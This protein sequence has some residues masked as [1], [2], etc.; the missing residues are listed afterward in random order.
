MR[1]R[2][3]ED[4]LGTPSHSQDDDDD[5]DLLLAAGL[6]TTDNSSNSTPYYDII[7]NAYKNKALNQDVYGGRRIS[8]RNKYDKW[9][10]VEKI[11]QRLSMGLIKLGLRLRGKEYKLF[12]DPQVELDKEKIKSILQDGNQFTKD[13]DMQNAFAAGGRLL[14][15][16]GSL[17]ILSSANK[18]VGTGKGV[19]KLD[20]M[21]MSH[22]TF[23]PKDVKISSG[24]END[25]QLWEHAT[26]VGDVDKVIMNERNQAMQFIYPMKE[27]RISLI[28]L[29]HH[30]HETRD[31]YNRNTIGIYGISLLELLEPTVKKLEDTMWGISKAMGRYGQ[32]RL[33][34]DDEVLKQRVLDGKTSL[35]KAAQILAAEQK[36]FKTMGPDED[37]I[38][39]GKTVQELGGIG[40]NLTGILALKEGWEKDIAYGLLES[41]PAAN[42][43]KGTTFASAY[44][45]DMDA[46]RVLESMRLQLKAGFEKIYARHLS[47]LGYNAEEANSIRIELQPID[48][49]VYDLQTLMELAAQYPDKVQIEQVLEMVGLHL[50]P[51]PTVTTNQELQDD[52]EDANQA[53]GL[54]VDKTAPVQPAKPGHGQP[55]AAQPATKSK[56]KN[57]YN[58]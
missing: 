31:I 24:F 20:F 42:K 13:L 53:L 34:I 49:P 26:M 39:I 56:P 46:V 51:A 8:Y 32:G 44:V 50:P 29:M 43:A 3:I 36:V 58:P 5:R 12:T 6:I 14:G 41:E 17:P 23:L 35:K 38:G 45:A 40:G 33:H 52:Q 27:G 37:I 25:Q 9:Q 21:P 1:I 15:R 22:T 48:E 30:G 11:N 19:T 54:P 2:E 16:D 18:Y 57:N 7:Q 55:P 28:R 47:L 4:I 10:Q